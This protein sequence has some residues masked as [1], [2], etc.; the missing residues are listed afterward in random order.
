MSNVENANN[1]E[2]QQNE[3]GKVAKKF[4][5][6]MKKLVALF[7]GEAI[8]RRPKMT[9]EDLYDGDGDVDG[10]ITELVSEEKETLRTEFKEKAKKL[11]QRKREFDAFVKAEQSKMDKAII[12]KKKEFNKEM[13]GCFGIIEKIENLEKS[14]YTSLKDLSSTEENATS[15][16]DT[17][18]SNNAD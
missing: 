6:N 5:S 12:E 7:K 9:T 4:D 10:V 16:D 15:G 13:D 2:Q 11:I 14:Y 3:N 8:F 17:G 1:G 18:S